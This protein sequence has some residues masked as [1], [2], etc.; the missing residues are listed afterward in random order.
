[1]TEATAPAPSAVRRR[2]LFLLALLAVTVPIYAGA[3]DRF[4]AADQIRYFHEM[5][6]DFRFSSTLRFWDYN[7]ARQAGKGDDQLFRPLHDLLRATET[8]LFG[9]RYRAWNVLH[10]GLHLAVCLLLFEL[11]WLLKPSRIAIGVALLFA[12]LTSNFELVVW[13]HLSGYLLGDA[14][15][16]AS[17]LALIR[18]RQAPDEAVRRRWILAWAAAAFGAAC[19]HEIFVIAAG[20]GAACLFWTQRREGRTSSPAEIALLAAPVAAYALLYAVHVAR[21]ER[22]LWLDPR[23]PAAAPLPLRVA[24]SLGSWTLRAWDPWSADLE[25]RNCDRFAWSATS[26]DGAAG[27]GALV[28]LVVAALGFCLRYGLTRDRLRDVGP[29]AALLGALLVAYSAMVNFGRSY[30]AGVTYYGYLF[31]LLAAV[32]AY[33]LVDFDRVDRRPGHVALALLLGLVAANAARTLTQT[34]RL[35]ALNAPT[36]EYFDTLETFVRAHRDEEGFAFGVRAYDEVDPSSYYWKG[37]PD[38]PPDDELT[39]S[40]LLYPAWFDLKLFQTGPDPERHKYVLVYR[41]PARK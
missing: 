22:W 31:A 18:A 33:A 26:L 39:V 16:L 3:L 19:C 30:A 1:M 24:Q 12:V 13:N 6:N 40:E 38:H 34:R 17:L 10:L 23:A 37:Y 11:L 25:F 21:C 4:F 32:L 7:A 36:I 5:R 15:F 35:A 28:L 2:P 29:V 27:R 8:S 41:P 9:Y 14:L 20:L